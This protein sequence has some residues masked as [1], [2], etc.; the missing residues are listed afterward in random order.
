MSLMDQ[1]NIIIFI[2]EHRK[3]RGSS[4]WADQLNKFK[5]ESSSSAQMRFVKKSEFD[6]TSTI[7][8]TWRA[9]YG[10]NY[11]DYNMTTN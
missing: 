10:Y 11:Y 7:S 1:L 4:V 6:L 3:L 5:G 8:Y 9:W 2:I